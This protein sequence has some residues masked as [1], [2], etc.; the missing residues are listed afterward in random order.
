MVTGKV[1][2]YLVSGRPIL[3]IGPVDGDLANI[4]KD[5]CTGVISDFNDKIRL[6]HNIETFYHQYK[7]GELKVESKN[8]EKYSR[9]YLAG[10]MADFLNTLTK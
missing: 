6:K 3:A 4:L 5:T 10:K 2:E 9:K 8:L 1:F 7:Q